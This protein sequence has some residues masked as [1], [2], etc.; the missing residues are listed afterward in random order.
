MSVEGDLV[1]PCTHH[2]YQY[3]YRRSSS[4]NTAVQ[5]FREKTPKSTEGS[6]RDRRKSRR[7]LMFSS[8]EIDPICAGSVVKS[9]RS[10]VNVVSDGNA[11]GAAPF[12][13]SVPHIRAIRALRAAHARARSH[14]C[15]RYLPIRAL[16]DVRT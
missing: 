16:S 6:V 10:R 11:P 4:Q 1:A 8:V 7:R 15:E 9:L 14:V 13:R 2:Q 3:Q 5:E 12:A